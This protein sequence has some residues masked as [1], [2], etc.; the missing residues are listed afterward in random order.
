MLSAADLKD[1]EGVQAVVAVGCLAERYGSELADAL[2]EADAV[3]GFDAYADI[4]RH[5]RRVL[6]GE[7]P[8]AHVPRDRRTLLPLAPVER[9]DR[10]ATVAIPGHRGTASPSQSSGDCT[11]AL[12]AGHRALAEPSPAADPRALGPAEDRIRL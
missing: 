2:P 5:V 7:R 1:T 10:L 12:R 6:G 11:G 9:R 3:L 8:A 4:G